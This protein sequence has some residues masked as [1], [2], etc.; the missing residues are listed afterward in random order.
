MVTAQGRRKLLTSILQPK[1]A[2]S[3]S[4]IIDV[5]ESWE[6]LLIRYQETAQQE[7]PQDVLIVAF[8]AL[9]PSQLRS[10]LNALDGI[11]DA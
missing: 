1:A 6:R 5:Q 4:D 11:C 8:T 3:Y 7:L 10:D 2:K 9:L